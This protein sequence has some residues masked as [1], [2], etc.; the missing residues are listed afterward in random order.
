MYM[1][2][3]YGAS[4]G[5]HLG[6]LLRRQQ[7]HTHTSDISLNCCKALDRFANASQKGLNERHMQPLKSW[8]R[9]RRGCSGQRKRGLFASVHWGKHRM[10]AKWVTTAKQSTRVSKKH[11]LTKADADASPSTS[12]SPSPPPLLMLSVCTYV[13]LLLPLAF[14]PAEVFVYLISGIFNWILNRFLMQNLD[15]SSPSLSLTLSFSFPLFLFAGVAS[16]APSWA[17]RSAPSALW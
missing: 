14:W 10:A 3:L 13:T 4:Y 5:A 7:N 1:Y 16:L 9:G 2:E 8:G 6:T 12:S 17:S 15:L 11:I